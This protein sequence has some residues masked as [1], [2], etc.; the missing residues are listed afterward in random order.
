MNIKKDL[1]VLRKTEKRPEKIHKINKLNK[2][3]WDFQV[4][5]NLK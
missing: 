5:I 4:M 1:G 3:K 2:I